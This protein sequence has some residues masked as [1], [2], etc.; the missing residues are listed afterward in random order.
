VQLVSSSFKVCV[1]KC[2]DTDFAASY[3][4]ASKK[5]LDSLKKQL[6]CKYEVDMSKIR[7]HNDVQALIDKNECAA[8]YIHSRPRKFLFVS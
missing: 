4:L 3:Y 5:D 7:S 1:E 8:W 2:P 6:I